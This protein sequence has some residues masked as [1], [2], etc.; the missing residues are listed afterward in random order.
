[1]SRYVDPE[2]ISS[3]SHHAVDAHTSVSLLKLM[4]RTPVESTPML[5]TVT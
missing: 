1:L 5:S 3:S 4:E 2:S